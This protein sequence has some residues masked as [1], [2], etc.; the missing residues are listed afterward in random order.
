M[1]P[2]GRAG[3]TGVATAGG[4]AFA[5]AGAITGGAGSAMRNEG[6]QKTK[7]EIDFGG[8]DTKYD[9]APLTG[10]IPY[11]TH[12]YLLQLFNPSI[13]FF[14][15]TKPGTKHIRRVTLNFNLVD[16]SRRWFA[17]QLAKFFMI[18]LRMFLL[19]VKKI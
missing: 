11:M 13:I 7:S 5:G 1:I 15:S 4:S 18:R 2:Q 6:N 14:L 17:Q 12:L 8:D 19:V 9:F 16:L 10:H 3:M